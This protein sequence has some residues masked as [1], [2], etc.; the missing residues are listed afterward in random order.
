MQLFKLVAAR[1]R[2]AALTFILIL[3]SGAALTACGGDAAPATPV[4][5]PTAA[6]SIDQPTSASAVATAG[7]PNPIQPKDSNSMQVELTEWAIKPANAGIPVGR[8]K[9]SVVNNGQLAHNLVIKSGNAEIARTP[10]F[11]NAQSPQLLDVDLQPGSYI[12]LCDIPG[13]S[14]KG[15]N[16]QLNVSK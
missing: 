14:E 16:G 1:S 10:T 11:T 13:H 4:T 8:T 7:S 5:Q 12:W 6:T 15:M 3:I 2:R 9:I